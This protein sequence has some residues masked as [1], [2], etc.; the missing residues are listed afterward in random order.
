MNRRV[1]VIQAG[2]AFP[3]VAGA[4][5]LIDCGSSTSPSEVADISSTSTVVNSHTHT[6]NVPSSNQLHPADTTYTSSTDAAHAHM[7]ARPGFGRKDTY[8]T[9]SA[10][11]TSRA[12]A[13]SL[14]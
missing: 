3:I 1:L 13:A 10:T 9:I 11:V 14:G 6:I 12:R 4:L 2:K 7:V 8:R 5:Y